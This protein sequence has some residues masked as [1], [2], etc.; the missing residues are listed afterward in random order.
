MPKLKR[1]ITAG[2]ILTLAL[3]LLTGCSSDVLQELMR[4]DPEEPAAVEE[5]EYSFSATTNYEYGTPNL[6]IETD[7]TYAVYINEGNAVSIVEADDHDAV[8]ATVAIISPDAYKAYL[9][10]SSAVD[11]GSCLT[12]VSSEKTSR[13]YPL[14][15]TGF[16]YS[17][18]QKDTTDVVSH[19]AVKAAKNTR[20]DPNKRRGNP[21]V[22]IV[23][24]KDKDDDAA[25]E[26][27]EVTNLS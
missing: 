18:S 20:K 21:N 11:D 16:Y 10:D 4:D 1:L 2:L 7:G 12:V 6:H 9:E 25:I 22:K 15:E 8:A 13:I 26:D 17:V 27:D 19:I 3:T 14:E 23:N 5:K 24:Q